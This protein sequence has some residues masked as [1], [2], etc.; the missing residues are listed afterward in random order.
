MEAWQRS[1]RRIRLARTRG[2]GQFGQ[3]SCTQVPLTRLRASCRGV[4]GRPHRP[5]RCPAPRAALSSHLKP[6][7]E[8]LGRGC[9]PEIGHIDETG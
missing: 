3:T 1:R 5:Q 7:S 9:A 4:I 8:P 2:A 6:D